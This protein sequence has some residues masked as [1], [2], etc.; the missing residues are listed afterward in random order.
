[1]FLVNVDRTLAKLLADLAN[2]DVKGEGDKQIVLGDPFRLALDWWSQDDKPKTWAGQQKP[3]KILK[4][5]I[6]HLR[7]F[8][9]GE[10]SLAN[11]FDLTAVQSG[12]IYVD[13]RAFWDESSL[14]YTRNDEKRKRKASPIYSAV[15]LLTLI[16][17][18]RFYPLRR[19]NGRELSYRIWGFPLP[20][21]VAAAVANGNLD[22]VAEERLTFTKLDRSGG[23][24]KAYGYAHPERRDLLW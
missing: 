15:E 22:S 3:E 16:G 12:G 13:A 2:C 4:A 8:V 11:L 19:K 14:G 1:M 20:V 6:E 21:T 18:Q 9:S 10:E 5:R 24:L 17:H 23:Y 7:R